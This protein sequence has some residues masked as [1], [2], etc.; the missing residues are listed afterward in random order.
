[1]ACSDATRTRRTLAILRPALGVAGDGAELDAA[2]YLAS[3]EALAR[4]AD[5]LFEGGARHPLIVGHNPGLEGLCARLTGEPGLT[6]GT[7]ARF[8]LR[9]DGAG[10]GP[11][12]AVA[13]RRDV[14][15]G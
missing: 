4:R 5:A 2:L 6:M 1:M 8:T 11:G 14:P 12:D 10:T 15:R 7:C 3:A 13:V 9:F